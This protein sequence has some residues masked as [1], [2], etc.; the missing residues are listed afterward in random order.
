MSRDVVDKIARAVLY[1]GYVLYPYRA[2]SVKNRQRWTFGGLF[3]QSWSEKQSTGDPSVMQTE[4]LVNRATAGATIHITF[5]FLHL[6]DRTVAALLEPL[7]DWPTGSEP[8]SRLVESL[9]VGD[10]RYQSWQEAVECEIDLGDCDISELLH[11]PT[12]R[13]FSFPYR[14]DIEPLREVDGSIVGMIVRAQQATD[15]IIDVTGL[16]LA[17]DLFRITVRVQ[18]RTPFTGTNRDEAQLR[19]LISTH[20]ILEARGGEFVSLTDPSPTLRDHAAAC[21]NIGAWPVLIGKEGDR[22]TLLASPMILPDYPQI[23]PESPGDLFDGTEIDEILTLRIMTLTDE[24]KRE[25]A[26]ADD[27]VR[28][29]FLRTE[30]LARE[31]LMGLHGKMRPVSPPQSKPEEQIQTWDPFATE[32]RPQSMLPR[33]NAH[34]VEFKPGDRVRLQPLGR[35][36]I[37]DIALDGKAATIVALEQDYEDRIHVVVTVDDDPGNDLGRD[38]RKPGHRFFFG[39]EEVELLS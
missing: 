8:A 23:A 9:S 15:G 33:V 39:I 30:S 17:D 2:S 28:D 21:R 27:R 26:G 1:E 16:R 22:D 37:F 12:H 6:I 32:P 18:N 11:T 20:T 13:A 7:A 29:L 25:A 36:D 10:R 35:A 31:Q 24:E 38:G 5:R 19:A 34:G 3:P 4:C 14:R